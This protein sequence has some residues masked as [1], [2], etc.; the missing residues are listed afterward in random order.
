MTGGLN[1]FSLNPEN[2]AIASNHIMAI[3]Y[4]FNDLGITLESDFLSALIARADSGKSLDVKKKYKVF[5]RDSLDTETGKNKKGGT[6]YSVEAGPTA[7]FGSYMIV[8]K[9]LDENGTA[10]DNNN[11]YFIFPNDKNECYMNHLVYAYSSE[12]IDVFGDGKLSLPKSTYPFYDLHRYSYLGSNNLGGPFETF[13]EKCSSFAYSEELGDT[14]KEEKLPNPPYSLEEIKF[15]EGL[16]PELIN[17]GATNHLDCLLSFSLKNNFSYE[18]KLADPTT[19]SS[20][21]R[22]IKPGLNG[23]GYNCVATIPVSSDASYTFIMDVS[24]IQGENSIPAGNIKI[25]TNGQ[26][27]PVVGSYEELIRL[28]GTSN[29]KKTPRDVFIDQ[30]SKLGFVN[31]NITIGDEEKQI[32]A[33]SLDA[34]RLM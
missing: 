28:L 34:F 6:L 9:E 22:S 16:F 32:E 10:I 7:D 33:E 31:F 11:R 8:I 23:F 18:T 15:I 13:S 26:P 4:F 14:L 2:T 27:Q 1:E 12:A 21:T 3:Q 5:S 30:L 25:K 17:E 29:E 19:K 24:D 20:I